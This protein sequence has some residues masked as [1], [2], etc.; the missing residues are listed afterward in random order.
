[1]F[2][3]HPWGIFLGVQPGLGPNNQQYARAALAALGDMT[4]DPNR[5]VEA[6]A[7]LNNYLFGFAHRETAWQQARHNSGLDEA[8]WTDRLHRYLDHATRR[9]SATAQVLA[10][11]LHLTSDQSFE[12]GLNCLLDGI[13]A[14]LSLSAID[15]G[16]RPN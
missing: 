7:L 6:L 5:Q 12:F 9:D 11:H 10:A 14:G 15:P 4:P 13:A 3:H 8:K 1:M 2:Q 16:S